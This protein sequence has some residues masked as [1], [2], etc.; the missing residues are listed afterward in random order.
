MEGQPQQTGS[1]RLLSSSEAQ[2]I[3]RPLRTCVSPWKESR[4]QGSLAQGRD[5]PKGNAKHS[6]T[7]ENRP[8]TS[9]E[10]QCREKCVLEAKASV[11]PLPVLT[12]VPQAEWCV[13]LCG[14]R[15]AV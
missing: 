9:S 15:D 2:R 13:I 7:Q 14:S 1:S 8:P 11:A 3:H 4:G 12:P 5:D 6:G 10:H